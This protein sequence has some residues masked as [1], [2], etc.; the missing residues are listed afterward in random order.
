LY[1][2]LD[3]DGVEVPETDKE[4]LEQYI[5]NIVQHHGSEKGVGKS[6]YVNKATFHECLFSNTHD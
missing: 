2:A 1:I 6:A 5:L 4:K 3:A